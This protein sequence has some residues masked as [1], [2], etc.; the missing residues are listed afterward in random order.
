MDG[1]FTG[2][3]VI[4]GILPLLAYAA[5]TLVAGQIKPLHFDDAAVTNGSRP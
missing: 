5:F 2:P 3:F 1:S 4:A